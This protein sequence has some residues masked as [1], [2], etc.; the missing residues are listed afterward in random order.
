MNEI[1]TIEL[2]I[3]KEI[4]TGKPADIPEETDWKELFLE[5]REQSLSSFAYVWI[6]KHTIPDKALMSN[7]KLEMSAYAQRWYYMLEEQKEIL[8]LLHGQGYAVAVLKGYANAYLFPYPEVRY[9]NDIDLLVRWEEYDQ[10]YEFLLNQGYELLEEK[11]EKKHHFEVKKNGVVFE[12]HKRPGGTRLEDGRGGSKVI[13]MFQDSMNQIEQVDLYGYSIPI[14]PP[15]LNGLMLLMHTAEHLHGG[16]GIRHLLDWMA[17]AE[18]YLNDD[19][20]MNEFCKLARIPELERLAMILTRTCQ[21]YLG[22]R[23]DI[24]WCKCIEEQTCRELMEYLIMEGDLGHKIGDQDRE[25]RLVAEAQG[26]MGFWTVFYDSSLYSLPAA[27][28]YKILLPIAWIYQAG[29]YLYKGL[30]RKNP[31]K[32]FKEGR[33]AGNERKNFFDR[34]GV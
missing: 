22:L 31:V 16:L 17:Y 4:M 18:H 6:D 10:I 15:M 3:I 24:V 28:K 21:I 19:I 33:R 5:T 12:I 11:E 26:N 23:E 1:E 34:L 25:V 7:W 32:S 13:H 29:R 8:N 9:S 2:E 20:W 30:L 27:R 14:L